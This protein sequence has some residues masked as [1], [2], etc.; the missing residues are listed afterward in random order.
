M[1]EEQIIYSIKYDTEQAEKNL[2]SLTA[3]QIKLKEEQKDL[4]QLYKF[5]ALTLEEYGQELSKNKKALSD[6]SK[7]QREQKKTIDI[8]NGSLNAQRKQLAELNKEYGDIDKTTKEGKKRFKELQK[9]INTLNDSIKEDE[10]AVGNFRRSVGDYT[11]SILDAA[12]Q[13]NILGINVGQA[14]AATTALNTAIGGTTGKLK[15]LKTALVSTG[16]GAVVV[17]LGT[18]FTYFQRTQAGSDELT[19]R[20]DQLSAAFNVVLDRITNVGGA[21]FE[22]IQGNISLGQFFEEVVEQAKGIGDEI[23]REVDLAGQLAERQAD[24]NRRRIGFITT[25]AQLRAAIEETRLAAEDASQTEE[26]RAENARKAQRLIRILADE[27]KSILAEELDILRQQNA[28]SESK[29]ADYE[30]EA[31]LQK[32]IFEADRERASQLKEVRNQEN[33][34]NK[35]INERAEAERRRIEAIENAGIAASL[36]RQELAEEDQRQAEKLENE[37]IKRLQGIANEGVR[38]AQEEAD[39]KTEIAIQA[40]EREK[41][42]DEIKY[43]GR[44]NLAATTTDALASLAQEESGLHKALASA[45]ALIDTY[46]AANAA[47]RQ[48]PGPPATIPF[49]IAAGI[50]GLANVARINGVQIAE[51]GLLVP[52][53]SGQMLHGP[54]H[55]NGGIH[56]EAEGGEVI[57]GKRVSQSPYLMGLVDQI[58]MAAGYPAL[59]PKRYMR[60]GGI[61]VASATRQVIEQ[62]GNELALERAIRNIPPGT[63]L[64][65]D[66]RKGLNN[67]ISV[68]NRSKVG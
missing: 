34:L 29:N 43:D 21:L 67:S 6:N 51:E 36:S 53:P 13:T 41:A 46:A 7:E 24:L 68:E 32:Q 12:K 60:D 30:K 63:V 38:I 35:V 45:T 37:S 55:T 2:A 52:N 33:N 62:N 57:L 64:V 49:A 50:Y 56:I 9:E 26:V 16:I 25:E 10:Q 19:K 23:E 39:K 31:E 27:R 20:I 47:L 11:N 3:E 1:A 22:L 8:V 65:K 5:G 61:A 58:S 42:I 18:L 54:S 48:F 40:A 14:V 44:L 17:L 59:S 15:L 4:T 66:L 28:L